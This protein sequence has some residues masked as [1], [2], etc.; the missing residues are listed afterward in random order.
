M[1]G[2]LLDERLTEIMP[3]DEYQN[4][5]IRAERAYAR[6][7]AEAPADMLTD[8]ADLLTI[9]QEVEG[10]LLDERSNEDAAWAQG[11]MATLA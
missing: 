3:R 7:Q 8:V 1:T 5:E 2:K 11:T 6:I 10:R 9:L 4:L